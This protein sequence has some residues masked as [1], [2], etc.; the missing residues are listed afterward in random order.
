M[1]VSARAARSGLAPDGGEARLWLQR[2]MAGR[3]PRVVYRRAALAM[4]CFPADAG[5]KRL[6]DLLVSY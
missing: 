3:G 2:Y 1:R 4:P 5:A 6:P